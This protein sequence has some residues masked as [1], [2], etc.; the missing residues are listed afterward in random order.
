MIRQTIFE[1]ELNFKKRM[2]TYWDWFLIDIINIHL[3]L[4]AAVVIVIDF[5]IFKSSNF[6]NLWDFILAYP[7]ISD[8]LF[9]NALFCFLIF[10]T[11]QS[12]V[13]NKN[14]IRF[15]YLILISI[16]PN[17]FRV[18]LHETRIRVRLSSSRVVIRHAV[19]RNCRK[20]GSWMKSIFASWAGLPNLLIF[21]LFSW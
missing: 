9:L 10:M 6:L 13:L 5:L 19:M 15:L 2:M 1:M 16:I 7:I 20:N 14:L 18:L 11:I 12:S 4:F 3:L 21:W 8:R 17:I